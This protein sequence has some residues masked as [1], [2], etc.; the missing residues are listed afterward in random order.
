MP[1]VT[2][3]RRKSKREARQN[4]GVK[5]DVSRNKEVEYKT[6]MQHHE[7]GGGWALF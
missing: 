2:G 1:E 6:H 7:T 3:K 5:K 4:K